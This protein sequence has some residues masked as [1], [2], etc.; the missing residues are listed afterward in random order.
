MISAKPRR[1]YL[2]VPP[3]Y[4]NNFVAWTKQLGGLLEIQVR[5]RNG[6]KRRGWD[7]WNVLA[8][9]RQ[10]VPRGWAYVDWRFC[11][12]SDTSAC[13]LLDRVHTPPL[14]LGEM[15]KPEPSGQTVRG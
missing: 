6:R 13:V 11:S 8:L 7:Q 4:N 9:M 10:L 3:P 12:F 5:S 1:R 14:Y 15:Y 2:R